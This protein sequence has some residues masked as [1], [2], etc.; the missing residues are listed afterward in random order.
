MALDPPDWATN[1]NFGAGSRPWN[2]QPNKNKPSAGIIAEG[3]DPENPL[4]A[5][6]LNWILN[7]HGQWIDGIDAGTVSIKSIAIDGVGGA[8]MSPTP[9]QLIIGPAPALSDAPLSIWTDKNGDL[10][11]IIDHLGYRR[12]RYYDYLE[13]YRGLGLNGGTPITGASSGGTSVFW[14]VPVNATLAATAQASQ[15]PGGRYAQ[16]N[17]NNMANGATALIYGPWM[18]SPAFY[19]SLVLEFDAWFPASANV[20]V[21][22]GL[23]HHDSGGSFVLPSGSPDSGAQEFAM[24]KQ[25]ADTHWFLCTADTSN[26][27]KTDTGI[28]ASTGVPGA[29][30]HIAMELHGASSP[31]GSRARVFVNG[32]PAI[33]ATPTHM[34][35][36]DLGM[37]IV[38]A[39]QA[40]NATNSGGVVVSPIRVIWNRDLAGV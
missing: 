22:I 38:V 10:R 5:D 36:L 15:M 6:F 12:G 32:A 3:F 35:T 31:Y 16:I 28:S 11:S 7:N 9:A 39:V 21:K 18:F 24:V 2:G 20:D 17:T 26:F 27:T 13:D 8:T 33:D 25:A 29:V 30:D 4:F 40:K 34:P 23:T 1:P 19:T 37:G 14:N